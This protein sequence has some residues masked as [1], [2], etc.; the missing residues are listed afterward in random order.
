M[1]VECSEA[2]VI[3]EGRYACNQNGVHSEHR[4]IGPGNIT[5]KW[6]GEVGATQFDDRHYVES[7]EGAKIAQMGRPS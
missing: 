1:E 5:V 6:K 3:G 4:A 7:K 2:V